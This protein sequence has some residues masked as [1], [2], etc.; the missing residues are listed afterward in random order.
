MVVAEHCRTGAAVEIKILFAVDVIKADAVGMV[1]IERIAHRAMKALA[2]RGACH[3]I[4]YKY[5]DMIDANRQ[6]IASYMSNEMGK[7]ILQSRAETTYAAEIGRANIEVGKHLY[8][9]VLCESSEGYENHVVMV[10]H[11]ALGVVA[12][13]IPFNY[14]VE[15]TIQKIVPALLMGNSVIVKAATTAPTVKKLV[16]ELGGNDP[17]IITEEVADDP[18]QMV[19]AIECLGWGRIIENNGQVCA[20]PKRTLVHKRAHDA[21]VKCLIK[22][23]EGLK[24]GHASDPSCQCTRLVSTA[25]AERVE[26]QI[27]HTVDQGARII[28][29][30]HRHGPSMEVT[31]LDGVTKDMD[32]AKDLE[33]FGPVV[34]IITFETDEEAVAIANQSKYG[35]SA[36]VIT[37]DLK[38][39]FY[40]TENI[41]SSAVWVN[42]SSAL[43]H[44]DQPFGGCK[45]TGI[46][47]EGA[48]YS[49]AEFSRLKTYG[50]CD[51]SPKDHL[52]KH[53]DGM[54]DFLNFDMTDIQA[55]AEQA[56]KG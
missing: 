22:F 10:R 48:G 38:K 33:I 34:P 37:K 4:L 49:C 19:K 52:F 21:F 41:E 44:N 47:N 46:G 9:K 11:E 43:R 30:G 40:Y 1:E 2:G 17:L 7:P 3:R 18:A 8:G 29:G 31:I 14:P 13:V 42:G 12:C 26:R 24:S 54:G 27:Q 56:I 15:L 55:V 28:Y 39:S 32:V 6:E 45:G 16:L 23:C 25:A 53:E 20:S 50:F 35:L 51:V 36:S 5:C